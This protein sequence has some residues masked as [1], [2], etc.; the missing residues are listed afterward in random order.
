LLTF[1]WS[2][3]IAPIK[4]CPGG[5][6]LIYSSNLCDVRTT[7]KKTHEILYAAAAAVYILGREQLFK[8]SV[9]E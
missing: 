3:E 8:L 4:I 6:T 5:L 9:T 1:R 2:A 7:A